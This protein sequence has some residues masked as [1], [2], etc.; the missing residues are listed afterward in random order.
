MNVSFI[1]KSSTDSCYR[2]AFKAMYTSC[3]NRGQG[4]LEHVLGIEA[5][6]TS[7]TSYD[8]PGL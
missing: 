1:Y 7:D 6:I 2:V 8:I 3:V 4:Q 5:D